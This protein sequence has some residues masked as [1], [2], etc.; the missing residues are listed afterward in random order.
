MLRITAGAQSILTGGG[1]Y[2]PLM[3]YTRAVYSCGYKYRAASTELVL[4]TRPDPR[5]QQFYSMSPLVLDAS[6]PGPELVARTSAPGAP[7]LPAR[8]ATAS[9]VTR[10]LVSSFR[11]I[12]VG[13]PYVPW[14]RCALC[15][16]PTSGR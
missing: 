1:R 13:K 2:D 10:A 12:L 9:P 15:V 3:P 14:E 7:R 4:Y 8:E 6:Q 5:K 11:N 16:R